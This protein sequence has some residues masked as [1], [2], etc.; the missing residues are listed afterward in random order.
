ML[1]SSKYTST[2][3]LALAEEHVIRLKIDK[4]NLTY[5][6]DRKLHKTLSGSDQESKGR[7]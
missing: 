2:G 4:Y 5:T 7:S 1:N 6:T 3:L